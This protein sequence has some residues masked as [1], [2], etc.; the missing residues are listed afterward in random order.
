MILD[1]PASYLDPTAEAAFNERLTN[2]RGGTTTIL[3]SH[4]FATV[5]Q[6]D[7]IAVLSRGQ[8]AEFG[9]HAELM[10]AKGHYA[11]MFCEQSAAFGLVGYAASPFRGAGQ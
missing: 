6:A 1:E 8:I 10:A 3:I 5:R 4:R 11:Q 9:S 7:R 2:L